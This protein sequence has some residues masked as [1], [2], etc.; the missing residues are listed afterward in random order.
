MAYIVPARGY[1]LLL[2]LFFVV[3]GLGVLVQLMPM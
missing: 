1:A 2:M 3:L